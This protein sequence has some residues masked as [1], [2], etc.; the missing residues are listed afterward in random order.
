MINVAARTYRL[1]DQNGLTI[2]PAA[3][4]I[5]VTAA[6]SERLSAD[7][8]GVR[9]FADG[10]NSGASMVLRNESRAYH[11]TVD[12]LTGRVRVMEANNEDM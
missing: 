11:V 7:E 12:W 5:E 9:F 6:E 8:I 4:A 1:D 3:T 2:K 10:S